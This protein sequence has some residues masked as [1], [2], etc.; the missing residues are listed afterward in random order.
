MRLGYLSMQSQRSR[1]YLSAALALVSVIPV[2]C[3]V[4]VM[5]SLYNDVLPDSLFLQN[6]AGLAGAL[7]ILGGYYLLRIY[8][9][10]LVRLRQYLEQLANEEFP[11]RAQLLPGELDMR[12][13]EYALNRV[14]GKLQE[15]IR[16]LDEAL[17]QSKSMLETIAAQSEE[18]VAAERQRVMIES[19]GAACHH[20]AQPTTLLS[21]YL[22]QLRDLEPETFAEQ[23]L[24]QCLEAVEQISEVLRKLK[25]TSEYRTV[26]YGAVPF[27]RAGASQPEGMAGMQILDINTST[28]EDPA[29]R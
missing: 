22:S 26:P 24:E 5:L 15:K 7:G 13:V 28:A 12:H 1:A 18:I 19:L 2:L 6:G 9:R 25:A 29:A 3:A 10:N 8:P 16:Q 27:R 20:I 11:E 17:Q 21:L 23:N 4:V 14:I